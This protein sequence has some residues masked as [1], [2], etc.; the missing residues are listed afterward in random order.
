MFLLLPLFPPL[1]VFL[2]LCHCLCSVLVTCDWCLLAGAWERSERLGRSIRMMTAYG[3]DMH[4]MDTLVN[5][6]SD[7]LAKAHV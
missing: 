5:I 6:G 4:S 7:V 3:S 2:C 1:T